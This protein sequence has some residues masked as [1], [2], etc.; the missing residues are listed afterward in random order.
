MQAQHHS[1]ENEPYWTPSLR[2][3]VKE[4]LAAWIVAMV[5]VGALV[6]FS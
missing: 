4:M 5:A 2:S 1:E 6:L 3:P